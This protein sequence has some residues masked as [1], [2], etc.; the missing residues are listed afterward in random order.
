MRDEAYPIFDREMVRM[1]SGDIDRLHE[2]ELRRYEESD[3]A[4]AIFD[5]LFFTEAV[6]AIS[7]L[8]EL[9]ISSARGSR[10][11]W[12]YVAWPCAAGFAAFTGYDALAMDRAPTLL[13]VKIRF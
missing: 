1:V 12:A 10:Y 4:W 13:I 3:R 9:A 2:I 7:A 6:F 8:S 11:D 5:G